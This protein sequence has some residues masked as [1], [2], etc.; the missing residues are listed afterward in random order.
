[1][2][3]EDFFTWGKGGRKVTPDQLAAERAALAVMQA[4]EGDT[5][6][7]AHWSQGLGRVVNALAG[8]YR[9]GKADKAEA[10]GMA[11]GQAAMDP[12]LQALMGG[13]GGVTGPTMGQPAPGDALGLIREFEGF[14]ETP[15]WDVNALR[16]GYGSDTVTMP[17]G[18]VVPVGK[19]TRVT[20]EDADRDLARR[21]GSEFMPRA[22]EAAGENWGALGPQQQAAL[23]SIAYNYGSVPSSVTA[24]LQTPGTEDDVAAIRGLASH[25]D[26]INA[27]RRNRE[28]DIY[29][30]VASPGMTVSTQGMPIDAM[31]LQM[32]QGQ[33]SAPQGDILSLLMAA[34]ADPWAAKQY[35]PVIN[36]LMGSELTNRQQAQD[37]LRQLQIQQAQW[38]LQQSQQP[39]APEP[40][41]LR[42]GETRYGADNQPL[43]SGPAAVAPRPLT[44][45]RER[46]EWGIPASDTRPYA[47]EEGKPPQLI[48]GSGVTVNNDLSG[49][50]KFEEAFAKGDAATIETVYNSGLAAQRNLGRIDQLEGLLAASP[51]GMA[52]AAKQAAGEWGINTEGL[53][54]LQSAQAMINS[55][56]PEQ[57][58][59][60]SGPMS[61]SD[62]ALFK[63]S[64]P[65][66][67][68]QPGGNKIIIDTMRAIAQYDAEG[69]AIVQR[70]RSGELNR[71]DAF[72]ALQ[73]RANP[74]ASVAGGAPSTASPPPA[75]IDAATWDHMTPEEKALFQ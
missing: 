16:T 39:Q 59:P 20:R 8:N 44:N 11:Q 61:D 60:G 47:I 27:G 56:V 71:A 58:Q 13:S 18:S 69:A 55:L 33:P 28:A 29:A 36:A 43:A 57:R 49:G 3:L 31:Q 15:Y 26:G 9:E 19:D 30:G 42:T 45:A 74:L 48:G 34:Q 52:G 25:N 21:V 51:T 1:M 64:L 6:P 14:R 24:A 35:G 66:I 32:P 37:P 75:G 23:T 67:I 2:A 50:G 63:Q 22:Q 62:L 5:S 12:V 7:V 72:D 53:D 65:R 17:D 73:N 38:D 40:Y 4:R 46:E 10:A 41:T 54:A 68:N 70:M